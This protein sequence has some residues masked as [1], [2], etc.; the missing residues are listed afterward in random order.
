MLAVLARAV[1]IVG[2]PM[3]VVPVA[4]AFAMRGKVDEHQAA[5]ILAA[6]FG[7]IVIVGIY[8]LYGVR[9]GRF[10]HIDVSRRE[11]RGSFYRVA[12]ASTAL[13]TICLYFTSAPRGA[14]FGIGTAFALLAVG[15]FLNRWTKAS[16]H[17]AF[18]VVA[19]GIVGVGA[20]ALFAVFALMAA[21]VAWSRLALARHT[22][23][24]V[25]VGAL[26]GIVASFALEWARR[27]V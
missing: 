11:E 12:L 15:S 19:A 1:S 25:V 23:S 6:V 18:A 9:T 13:A 24:E 3:V 27:N 4:I 26:L 20:P 8:L 16:L 7:A 17:T 21:A 2:H 10:A 22:R 5:V 14:V